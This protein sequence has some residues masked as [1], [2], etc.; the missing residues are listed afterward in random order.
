MQQFQKVL[1]L[2]EL[3]SER[4]KTHT[5]HSLCLAHG[6]CYAVSNYMFC[7][8]F[9]LDEKHLRCISYIFHLLFCLLSRD[10][11]G[12]FID[13]PKPLIAVVNGP[14][15]G[16]CVTVLGLCDLVYA[17]DRVS[18]LHGLSQDSLKIS[19]CIKYYLILCNLKEKNTSEKSKGFVYHIK[20][21]LPVLVTSTGVHQ[22]VVNMHG[23]SHA[24]VMLIK[25]M[26]PA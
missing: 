21:H 26:T 9:I 5:L 1:V 25:L 10:F 12:H 7:S 20:E 3:I 23:I 19:F 6:F 8:L 14:A 16:I 11:V 4:L 22:P 2:S 17:S 24:V 13:F 15:I 18:T